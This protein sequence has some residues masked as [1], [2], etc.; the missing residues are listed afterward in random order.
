MDLNR[1]S[2][3]GNVTKSPE[4]RVT[5]TGQSVCNFS[6]AT[7][8]SWNDQAGQ[9]QTR[10]T[11][12]SIVVWGKLAELCNSYLRKGSKIFVEGRIQYREWESQ[13]GTK[14]NA[15]EIVSDNVIFLEKKINDN[16]VI[17]EQALRNAGL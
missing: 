10:V 6:V 5:G 12:H 9:K 13:D 11:Y 15:T 16:P 8:E 2:V 1:A 14:R 4:L 17:D 7:N 3:L